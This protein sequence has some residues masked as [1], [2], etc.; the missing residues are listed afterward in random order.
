MKGKRETPSS[1]VPASGRWFMPVLVVLYVFNFLDRQIVN[2]L[3]EPIKTD[4]ALADWQVGLLTG[5]AFALIYTV[6]GIPIARLAAWFDR[7]VLIGLSVG[8]WSLFTTLCGFAQNFTQLIAARVGVGIGEAGMTP[9]AHSLIMDISPHDKRSSALATYG[10]GAPLGALLGMAFG[11]LVADAV[12]W[13]H[14]FIWIGLPGLLLAAIAWLTLPEPRRAKREHRTTEGMTGPSF[15]QTLAALVHSKFVLL[16]AAATFLNSLASSGCAPFTA[17]F[18]LRNH[19]EGLAT[20]ASL[21]TETTGLQLGTMGLLGLILGALIGSCG[22]L[23]M[24]IGGKLTDH[25]ARTQAHW[26]LTVPALATVVGALTWIAAMQVPSLTWAIPLLALHGLAVAFWYGPVYAAIYSA[27]DPQMRPMTSAI[28]LFV[29]NISGLG[30]GPVAV[31]LTSDVLSQNLGSALGIKMSMTLFGLLGIFAALLF[32][33][34]GKRM[35]GSPMPVEP[36]SGPI[37]AP[38]R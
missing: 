10:L 16:V 37:D 27:V 24:V 26:Q 4:L 30:I 11:G 14:A 35:T 33:L 9:A 7:P 36:G 25:L 22:V 15:R 6:M 3:A 23:G 8:V 21:L 17:S 34:G 38:S 20:L 29:I 32:W 12:G 31:G 28:M 2:I 13:R 1:L 5:L 19:A 18:L